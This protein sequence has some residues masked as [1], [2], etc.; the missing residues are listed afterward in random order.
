MMKERFNRTKPHVNV[1]TIGH[2][3]HGKTTVTA[4]LSAVLSRRYG[5]SYAVK[6][7]GD[8]ARG[9]IVR[10][11][12]KTLTVAAGHAEFET[13]RRHYAH[14]DCPGHADYIKNM[15]TGAA[16]MDGA[17]LVVS[18]LDSIMPQTR[19]H[20]LLARQSGVRSMVVFVNKCDAVEDQELVDL[21]EI[22]ARELLEKV[23]FAGDECAVVRGAALPALRGDA[24]WEESIV[25]LAEALDTT[26]PD[27]VRDVDGPFLLSVEGVHSI[28]GVGTVVT[29]VVD[30]GTVR[31]GDVVELIA[32]SAT[33]TATVTGVE[34]FKQT[35]DCARAGD[36]T[37][38]CL[39]NVRRDEVERGAVLAAP[40][41]AK[42]RKRFV[43]ELYVLTKEE[44]GRHTPFA[45]RYQPQF[46]VRTTDVSGAV[47]LLEGAE[48]ARP[49]DTVRVEVELV[50]PVVVD[51]NTRFS[52][53]EGGR[54]VGA[55]S[56]VAL[57]E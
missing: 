22:E 50:S 25:A 11:E 28:R 13:P 8:I 20:V 17:I 16:Q 34:T 56:V 32:N 12:T 39:R 9:G 43:A 23:G 5:F 46:F 38:L 48:L 30:R 7:Y 41:S 54:T 6:G 53:R 35:L 1:G 49:G 29:G 52:I 44:G 55:G 21:V 3:D 4:A 19:E 24:R 10:D 47:T 36:N 2:I 33:R 42:A 40:G 31:V 57:V 15:M 37:G 45:S 18:A 27:P 26:I 51:V 14:V